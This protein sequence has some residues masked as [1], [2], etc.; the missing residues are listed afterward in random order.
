[1]RGLVKMQKAQATK[2]Q[3]HRFFEAEAEKYQGKVGFYKMG[4]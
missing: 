4:D 1:M 2:N 3:L